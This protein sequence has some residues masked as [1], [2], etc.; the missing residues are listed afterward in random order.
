MCEAGSAFK[1]ARKGQLQRHVLLIA[2]SHISQ[3]HFMPRAE[4]ESFVEFRME[5]ATWRGPCTGLKTQA[6]SGRKT[7]LHCWTGYAAGRSNAAVLVCD[8]MEARRGCWY[9]EM[10]SWFWEIV[11]NHCPKGVCAC[12]AQCCR[13]K[14]HVHCGQSILRLLLLTQ[15]SLLGGF[16]CRS[17]RCVV[18]TSEA[19]YF[20]RKH[21]G[22]VLYCF[23]IFPNEVFGFFTTFSTLSRFH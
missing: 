1:N 19:A 5:D 15:A 16:F 17:L 18:C 11:G 8:K 4:R 7:T 14:R 20:L 23:H 9:M 6:T 12:D 3:A 22:F 13:E 2:H 10:T 21:A